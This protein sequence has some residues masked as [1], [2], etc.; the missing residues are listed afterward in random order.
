M[1][2][3]KQPMVGK[4]E[5]ANNVLVVGE[6]VASVAVAPS[7]LTIDSIIAEYKPRCQAALENFLPRVFDEKQIRRFFGNPEYGYDIQSSSAALLD[8]IWDLLDRGGKQW[9]P[10]L[11]C[12]ITEVLGGRED[13][14][15]PM[16]ALCE[17][18]HNG[19]LMIDDVEDDS[20]LRRGKECIHLLY[21]VDIA[22][23]AGNALYFLPLLIFKEYR[24]QKKVSDEVLL[25]CY[26]LYSQEL[27]NVHLGQGLDIHWHQGKKNPGAQEYLQ[28]C[29][30]KTGVLARLSARLG[31]LLS[32]A[33]PDFIQSI[34]KFAESI[35]VAFQIQ[36]DLLNIS[37][38]EF[39]KK[40][41]I[42]GEDIHEGKRSLMVIHSLETA[43]EHKRNR[44][45]EILDSKTSDALI[46]KEAID[47]MKS[48]NSL[49]HS[50][51]VASDIISNAWKEIEPL[52]PETPAKYKLKVFADYLINRSI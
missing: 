33:S 34:G 17:M 13:I 16:A 28:M 41:D 29:A 52:L 36:D 11:L 27:L 23:N 5:E 46:I 2:D 14:V 24:E 22:I 35:G 47:I 30:Y 31:A 26:E 3:G 40:I 32:G 38:E 37:G 44:L 48:T 8:P 15:L 42:M 12:L 25:K 51:Q 9:R 7:G 6:K 43:P 21:G 10:I 39:A 20:K 49:V 4:G 45:I 1:V 18:A 50:K 19:T